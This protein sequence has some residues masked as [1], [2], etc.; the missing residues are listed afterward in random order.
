MRAIKNIV[1]GAIIGSLL[2]TTALAHTNS[3]GYVSDANANV[4]F[5]YGTYHTT[6]FN[7]AELKLEGA[8]GTTYTTTITQFDQLSSTTPNGL[9]PGINYFSTDQNGTQLIDYDDTTAVGG[10]S[11]SWQG[12]TFNSLTAGDY[13]FT[14]IPLGD[15]ESYC[16]TCSPTADWAP[17]NEMIRSLTVSIDSALLSGDANGNGILDSLETSPASNAGPT[18][19]SQGSSSSIAYSMGI[20]AGVQTVARTQTDTTWDNMSDGTTQNTQSTTT[21][22]DPFVGRVDQANEM[23]RLG[24]PHQTGFAQ[25]IT[26][27]RTTHDMGNGYS[28][29]TRTYSLGHTVATENGMSITGGFSKADT[30]LTGENSTGT[31]ATT[32]F[33]VKVGK[34]LDSRDLTVSGEGHVANSELA[35]DRTVGDFG[36]AGSTESSERWGRLQ[37]EKSTGN[38]RPFAAYTVGNR[39][40]DEWTETGDSTIAITHAASDESYRYATIGMNLDTGLLTASFA[41]DFDDAETMR[42]GLGINKHLNERVSFGGNVSRV[43]AGDNTSTKISAGFKIRF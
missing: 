23:L 9:F 7:E 10:Q 12:L 26:G 21:T 14:Y 34:A 17:M 24:V 20:A 32:Q 43:T 33:G 37:V 6:N 36:A 2:S 4:T 13:T 28:A 38:L 22:L 39:S 35:Y 11:N 31:M 18:V 15:T 8:N 3:I 40:V 19:D 25:G 27:S 29:E 30:E 5:W 16:T 42:M 1:G 41:R